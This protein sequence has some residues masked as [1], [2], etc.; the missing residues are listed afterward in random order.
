MF[1]TN[2]LQFDPKQATS[3]LFGL[4]LYISAVI[5]VVKLPCNTSLDK[6]T[7]S[8]IINAHVTGHPLHYVVAPSG[9]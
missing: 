1:T 3:S 4:I 5:V 6:N 7:I 9:G 8:G 2:T